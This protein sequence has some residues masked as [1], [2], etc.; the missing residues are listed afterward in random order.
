MVGLPPRRV[1]RRVKIMQ[2]AVPNEKSSNKA[3]PT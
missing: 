1:K 2:D 3:L